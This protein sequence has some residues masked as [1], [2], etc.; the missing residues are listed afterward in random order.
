[1]LPNYDFF[2]IMELSSIKFNSDGMI[3]TNTT[4]EPAD[5]SAGKWDSAAVHLSVF[6]GY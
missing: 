2:D 4:M 1:M 5:Q 3:V 6:A